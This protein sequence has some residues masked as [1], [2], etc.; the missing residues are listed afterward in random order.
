MMAQTV[1]PLQQTTSETEELQADEAA[2]YLEYLN[3]R[4]QQVKLAREKY[5]EDYAEYQK[6]ELERAKHIIASEAE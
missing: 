3:G 6:R 5:P 1:T 2:A 4:D